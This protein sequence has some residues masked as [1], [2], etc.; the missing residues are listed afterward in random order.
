MVPIFII[1]FVGTDLHNYIF[2]AGKVVEDY[3]WL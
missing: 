1:K 2:R 3:L